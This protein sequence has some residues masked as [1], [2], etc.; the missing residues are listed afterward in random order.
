MFSIITGGPKR[1]AIA[2]E[3]FGI[4][5]YQGQHGDTVAVADPR[6][7]AYKQCADVCRKLCRRYLLT[8]HQDGCYTVAGEG[9]EP[10]TVA[11]D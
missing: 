11:P 4:N 10:I 5:L 1:Y 3:F 7:A 8:V 9:L 2:R 6:L